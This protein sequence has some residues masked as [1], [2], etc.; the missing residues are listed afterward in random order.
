MSTG[1]ERKALRSQIKECEKDI[2]EMIVLIQQTKATGGDVSMLKKMLLDTH[3]MQER[4]ESV[5][6]PNYMM[7]M[8]GD[9]EDGE[10]GEDGEDSDDDED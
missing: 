10:D 3:H 4:W 7:D 8:Y 5:L 1:A 6:D 2:E 9:D